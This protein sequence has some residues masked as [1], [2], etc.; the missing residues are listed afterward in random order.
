MDD[1]SA[2]GT[3]GMPVTHLK[4]LVRP[5]TEETAENSGLVS[6]H[7]FVCLMA[8]GGVGSEAAN[9]H[10]WDTLPGCTKPNGKYR[11]IAIGTVA[12]QL[13]SCCFIKLALSGQLVRETF[14][15]RIKSR[16]GCR[17]VPKSRFTC[18]GNA[19][20]VLVGTQ[21]ARSCLL[22]PVTRLTR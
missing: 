18:S 14:S 20:L 5:R 17:R 15:R 4:L 19:F 12:H 7:N 10:A 6:L 16:T 9:F 1:H 11:P 8:E 3:A 13:V 21:A 2:A 22:T